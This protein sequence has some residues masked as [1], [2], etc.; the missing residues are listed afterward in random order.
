[1]ADDFAERA[2]K[3]DANPVRVAMVRALYDEVLRELPDL[4]GR[5]VLEFGCGTGTLGLRLG[6]EH[7]ARLIFADTSPAML[8]VLRGKLSAA[9]LAEARVLE[10][11]LATLPLDAA[12]VDAVLCSMS[13]HHVEDVPGVLRQFRRLLKP[14]GLV[15]VADAMPEDGSFHAP[16]A[17]PHNGFDPA[18]LAGQFAAAGFA[19]GPHRVFHLLQKPDANGTPREYPLFLLAALAE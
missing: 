5:T 13:L 9:P 6:R 11:E 14:G 16:A 18:D 10:G 15:L 3:W 2:E 12:T 4:A 8:A 1:M 17:V 7:S 19:P